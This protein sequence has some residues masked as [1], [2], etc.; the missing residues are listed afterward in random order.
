MFYTKDTNKPYFGP[1]FSL[2]IN[3]KKEYEGIIKYGKVDGLWT[4]WYANGQKSSEGT[5]KDG[6][7]NGLWTWWYANGQKESEYNYKD[8]K[9][10]GLETNWYENGNIKTEKNY[11]NGKEWGLEI[12][13]HDNGNIKYKD[14]V[15]K[16][17]GN[18]LR[19]IIFTGYD[20]YGKLIEGNETSWDGFEIKSGEC[21]KDNE[22]VDCYD[23]NY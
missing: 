16:K 17:S 20:K 15:Y 6:T 11:R 14:V 19:F 10:D 23:P 4:K 22:L 9:Q 1:V 8:G 5:Y 12:L 18:D 2:Y 13:Y 7:K 3:G 21:Y